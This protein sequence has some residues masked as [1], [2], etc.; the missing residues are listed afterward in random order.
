MDKIVHVEDL[1][2]DGH[3]DIIATNRIDFNTDEQVHVF[4]N[5]GNG[6]FTGFPVDAYYPEYIIAGDFDENGKKDFLLKN[7]QTDEELFLSQT[8]TSGQLFSPFQINVDDDIWENST[9]V[10]DGNGDGKDEL[11]YN[12][13]SSSATQPRGV[14]V[15]SFSSDGTFTDSLILT[16]T[17]NST[18][19]NAIKIVDI[20]EDGAN[21]LVYFDIGL[22]SIRLFI[23]SINNNGYPIENSLIISPY[24][25]NDTNNPCFYDV[26]GD[27]HLDIVNRHAQ[28]F[29][30]PS[31]IFEDTWL[32][33]A[34]NFDFNRSTELEDF[35]G[36]FTDLNSDGS[37]DI[38]F[39]DDGKYN[40]IYDIYNYIDQLN[41][42]GYTPDSD[43]DSAIKA[44]FF[45]DLNGDGFKDLIIEDNLSLYYRF[46]LP[47][48]KLYS[49]VHP[50]SI[51]T[52]IKNSLGFLD[53]NNT[54]SSDFYVKE[55]N[56]LYRFTNFNQK[57]YNNLEMIVDSISVT[58]LGKFYADLDNDGD[59]DLIG[60]YGNQ[61]SSNPIHWWSNEDGT[62]VLQNQLLASDQNITINFLH[63]VDLDGDID[64][65][66]YN[67]QDDNYQLLENL[68]L[69]HI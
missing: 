48:R 3:A 55:G 59:I 42:K 61:A 37:L 56:Q 39:K 22:S 68:S 12:R 6:N 52:E 34:G 46:F 10:Y 17:N 32:K 43:E 24:F 53:L 20:N 29:V 33:N 50:L 45:Y 9:L 28:G 11:W 54:G 63:D 4:V 67:N 27:Q 58:S 31:L 7:S 25:D 30:V 44:H 69:I 49:D 16:P 47:D 23:Y 26:D 13:S 38:L 64:I 65:V 2:G 5:D 14:Y 57:V 18:D 35:S 60:R 41:R 40:L 21:E 1:T 66:F 36:L 19:R 62:F 15:I 51:N 8:D